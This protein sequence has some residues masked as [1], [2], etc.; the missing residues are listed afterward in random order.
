MA[1]KHVYPDD[2]WSHAVKFCSLLSLTAFSS[3]ET[4]HGLPYRTTLLIVQ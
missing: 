3:M 2:I 4:S 1:L